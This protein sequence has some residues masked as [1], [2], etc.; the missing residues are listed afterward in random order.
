MASKNQN[1]RVI[2]FDSEKRRIQTALGR[3]RREA[4]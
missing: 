4:G 1:H 3:I 2:V